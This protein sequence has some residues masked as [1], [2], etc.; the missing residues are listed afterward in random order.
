[1]RLAAFMTVM[2][3][4]D[5]ININNIDHRVAF[6]HL[7]NRYRSK[8]GL[9]ADDECLWSVRSE[10]LDAWPNKVATVLLKYRAFYRDTTAIDV[11][12][13]ARDK[14]AAELEAFTREK[15][16][17][18]ARLEA[19]LKEADAA[20]EQQKAAAEAAAASLVKDLRHFK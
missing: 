10:P 3:S 14:A 17:Q 11:L 5:K 2:N 15:A 1:M 20:F 7:V 16:Q 9:F 19:E 13:A 12:T 6:S 8:Y 18:V 4:F